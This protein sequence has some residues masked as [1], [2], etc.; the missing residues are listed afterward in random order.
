MCGRTSLFHDTPYL[1]E[2]FDARAVADIPE[3]YNI[4]PGQDLAVVG[5]E[6]PDEIDL[7]EWGFVP[8][9]ADDPADVPSP[10]NARSETAHEKP[11]FRDAFAERRCLVLADGFYEWKGRRGSK[12]PYR[13]ERVDGEPYA[14][15][16]LWEAWSPTEGDAAADGGQLLSDGG[17]ET[18]V[19]CTI[20]TCDANQV[21]SDIHDR[22]PVML[23]PEHES[24]WLDGGDQEELQSVLKPYPDEE[25][26]A[27]PVSKRVNDPSNDSPKVLEEIDIGE[28]SGLG[29]FGD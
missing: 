27:Y 25:L 28:Q 17:D 29:D 24:R 2:R 9:W 4:A 11:M 22:M 8:H 10:I 23:E 20:L 1:E 18:R 26:R 19:T 5:D 3:R 12:Q 13:V 16:G 7:F 14:Y 15:A 6:A 21:V